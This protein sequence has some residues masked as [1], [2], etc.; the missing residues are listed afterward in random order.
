MKK[1]VLMVTRILVCTLLLGSLA[2]AHGGMEHILGTVTAITDHSLSVKT[3]EGAARTVEFDGETRFVKGNV[4]ATIK[5]VQVG[6]RVAIHAHKNENSM[7]AT[8]VRVGTDAA[9]GQR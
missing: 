1:L 7:H 5:D 2:F 6:S 9:K 3:R 8:E 4:P